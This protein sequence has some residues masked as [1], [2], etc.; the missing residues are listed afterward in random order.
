MRSIPFTKA[1]AGGNDFLI[2]EKTACPPG[3]DLRSL[4][5]QMCDRH[6][7][8]G[9]DGVE[10]I[11][12]SA[13]PDADVVADL[14]NSDGSLAEIS[15]NGTRCVAAWYVSRPGA[16]TTVVRVRTGAG[17]KE[18]R[19]LTRSL[20][21]Y[22]FDINMGRARAVDDKTVDG[23]HGVAIDMGNPHFVVFRDNFDFDWRGLALSLQS[24]KE[25]FPAGV[26]VEIAR[27][28]DRHTV[29]VRLY[30]RGVGE[31]RS[32]GTG[33]CSVAL[34]AIFSRVCDS[35]VKV[36]SAGGAQTV[37]SEDQLYLQGDAR[38]I[39]NGDFSISG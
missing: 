27:V 4:A 35:P 5:V 6:E 26:N 23:I 36:K 9:A 10:F 20:T 22:G 31:T 15:G 32:S 33:S 21:K 18:C 37:R 2:V 25:A 16:A 7:G 14:I 39:C 19:L 1:G 28:H 11:S 12:A 29:E 38:L 30:E 3:T 13:A 8:I 17:I 34:A 24:N